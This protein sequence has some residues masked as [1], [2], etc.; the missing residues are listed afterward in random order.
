MNKKFSY[1]M[2]KELKKFS[3]EFRGNNADYKIGVKITTKF[4]KKREK[5]K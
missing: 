3:I 4:E 1:F 2:I 5:K